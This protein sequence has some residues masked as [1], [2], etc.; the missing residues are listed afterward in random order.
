MVYGLS[1][2]SLFN[3]DRVYGLEKQQKG[4]INECDL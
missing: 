1:P 2:S 3:A 4:K